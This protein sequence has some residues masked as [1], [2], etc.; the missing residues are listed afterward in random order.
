ME[1]N[2]INILFWQQLCLHTKLL[3]PPGC[4]I[5]DYLSRAP[6]APAFLVC[7]NAIQLLN[8]SEISNI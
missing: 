1:K 3:A 6:D 7:K 2:N 4:S 8:V 5:E